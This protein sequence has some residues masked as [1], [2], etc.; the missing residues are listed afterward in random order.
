MNVYRQQVVPKFTEM[1]ARIGEYLKYRE[2]QLATINLQQT[3]AV[4]ESKSLLFGF[5]LIWLAVSV[6]LGVVLTRSIVKP[7]ADAV[8]QLDQ[9]A[10]GDVSRD[11][12]REDLERDDEIGLLSKAM[13]TM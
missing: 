10:G 5:A 6:I 13:Q 12:P 7:L 8:S 9:V 1:S 4:S 3:A 2:A 11:L